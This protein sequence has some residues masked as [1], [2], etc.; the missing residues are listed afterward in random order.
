MCLYGCSRAR[1]A[2]LIEHRLHMRRTGLL[3]VAILTAGSSILYHKRH[4][5]RKNVIEHEM[6]VLI[7]SS[8]FM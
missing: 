4:D 6:C 2:L 1:V 5:L 8:S 3:F 7:F